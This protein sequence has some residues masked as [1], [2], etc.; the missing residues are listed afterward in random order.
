LDDVLL[1]DPNIRSKSK[2]QSA[3]TELLKSSAIPCALSR[4]RK[5]PGMRVRGKAHIAAKDEIEAW[6][7]NTSKEVLREELVSYTATTKAPQTESEVV[8]EESL[9]EMTF[10]ALFQQVEIHAPRLYG[11]LSEICMAKRKDMPR[12]KNS[13]FCITIFINAMAN[14]ISQLNNRMQ[15]LLCIYFKAKGVP[16]S[17]Y[18]LFY[19]CGIVKSYRWSV[20]ALTSISDAA[21]ARAT[22]VFEAQPCLLIHDNIRLPFPV[23]HQRGDHLTTT[24]NGTAM[25]MLPLR[26]PVRA[27]QLLR[28]PTLW[29]EQK[30]KVT[31]MYQ[32]NTMPHLKPQDL[33]AMPGFLS[34][35]ERTISNVVGFLF[36]IPQVKQSKQVKDSGK[37]HHKLLAEAPPVHQLPHGLEH[38]NRQYMLQ[39]VPQEEATYGGNYALTKEAPRQLGIDSEEAQENWAANQ[40]IPWVGDSL[41]V[42]RLRHL[43]RMKCEDL[44]TLERLEHIIPTFGWFH[45][46]MNLVNSIFYH[47]YAEKSVSGLARDA[48][49]LRRAGLT[50][51]TKKRGP[52]YHT[53]DEFLQH[54]TTARVRELWLWATKTESV[55]ALVEWVE[56]SSPEQIHST[57][58]RIWSER[59]SNRAIETYQ[60]KDSNLCNTIALTRD[61]LLRHE[62]WSSIHCGD[63]GRMENTMPALLSFFLGAGANNYAK[64]VA[65][66]LHWRLHEAPPGV[67]DL[68]RDECWVV[69]T[70]GQANTFYPLDLRQELNNLSIKQEH[71]PPPKGCTWEAH[72]KWAPALPVL[73]NVVQH[74]DESFH[75]FYRSRKHYIPDPENDIK[76][77]MARHATLNIH[78][79]NPDRPGHQQETRTV[80]CF[81]L[82]QTKLANG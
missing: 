31:G 18:H 64:E 16:K 77:L 27:E 48:A 7:L 75:D 79:H 36:D 45:L 29:R 28:N 61:L 71:G 17:V 74:V 52:Q 55:E 80:D 43:Q 19:R 12:K 34:E 67:A 53:G 21:M 9:K 63:V 49:A 66:M 35:R 1:G 30:E 38:R 23:K 33:Y 40:K 46:D 24:D 14:Q 15:K 76:M 47:H 51:P 5:P 65:E 60:E 56:M 42:Q 41:T 69:N 59:A 13:N 25:T 62:V 72:R 8:D 3:R 82:G 10:E 58:E 32:Q 81:A 73:T 11:L 6:A 54:T 68:I 70:R 44:S 20:E 57:A 50:K 22:E 37:R 2:V 78:K 4:I 26:D 39:S